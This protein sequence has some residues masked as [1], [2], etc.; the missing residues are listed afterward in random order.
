MNPCVSTAGSPWQLS[1]KFSWVQLVRKRLLGGRLDEAACWEGNA[2]ICQLR[3]KVG[4]NFLRGAPKLDLGS[5]QPTRA[6]AARG[7]QRA[8]CDDPGGKHGAATI[9]ATDGADLFTRRGS[10]SPGGRLSAS[11]VANL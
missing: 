3:G 1:A 6:A 9:L 10:L 7:W 11:A 5:E 8:D 2:G 4:G